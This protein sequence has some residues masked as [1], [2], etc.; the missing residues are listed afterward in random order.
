MQDDVDLN[1]LALW[2]RTIWL[3][4]SEPDPQGRFRVSSDEELGFDP[5]EPREPSL[6]ALSLQS[7]R[8]PDRAASSP[9]LEV[10]PPPVFR[11]A[12]DQLEGSIQHGASETSPLIEKH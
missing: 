12:E 7:R 4:T 8:A 3:P 10:Q 9:S 5:F 11:R 1:Q 2:K 6:S